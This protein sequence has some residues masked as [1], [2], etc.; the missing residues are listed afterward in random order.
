MASLYNLKFVQMMMKRYSTIFT[1]QSKSTFPLD[2]E[3]SHNRNVLFVVRKCRP[4]LLWSLSSILMIMFC[5]R[6]KESS[7][8]KY[9]LG[10]LSLYETGINTKKKEKKRKENWAMSMF[11]F[12]LK[13]LWMCLPVDPVVGMYTGHTG[14]GKN[15]L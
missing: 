12:S 10:T 8:L 4:S 14:T 2:K 13:W 6:I 3:D 11:F 15:S 7:R 5:S 9:T 1:F